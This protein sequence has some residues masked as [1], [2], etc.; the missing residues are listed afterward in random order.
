M[1]GMN[2]TVERSEKNL[3][4]S[5]EIKIFTDG[6]ANFTSLGIDAIADLVKGAEK[7]LKQMREEENEK[8]RTD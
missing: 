1:S 8:V 7:Q 2:I 3:F 4:A 5:V 6:E